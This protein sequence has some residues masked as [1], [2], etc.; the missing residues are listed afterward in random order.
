VAPKTRNKENTIYPRNWRMKLRGS[1]F[2]ILFRVP[3]RARELWGGR[4]EVTLG[5][6]DTLPAAEKAAYQSWADK[7]AFSETP[8]TM[9]TAFD[10]YQ[11][12]VLPLKAPAT[13][14]SNK[15][16]LNRLRAVIPQEMPVTEFRTHH[17]YQY[18]DACAKKE[19]KK[20][21]NL[22]LEVL[23]HVFTKCFEWGT[24]G[25]IEHPIVGKMSKISLPPRTRYPEDW[26]ITEFLKVANK[27]HRVY[28]PLKY[29]LGIDKSLM[30]RIQ[31]SSIKPD[32]LEIE[33][34]IKIKN[35]VK[36]K[37][38]SYMFQDADGND[39]GLKLIIDDVL[40][41][42][43]EILKERISPWLFCG[44][45]GQPLI[46][47]DGIA[48]TFDSNW[49]RAMKRALERTELVE[50]FTEHDIC[51]KTAS[52]A[53]TVEIAAKMRGHLNT[54]TTDKVYR[55]LPQKVMPLKKNQK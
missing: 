48:S 11:A 5:I 8:H 27:M 35:N 38:K 17:A 9:G 22:D 3:I 7:I 19:S 10:R 40:A 1:K 32:R 23:S 31:L 43:K 21:A 51:A 33:K 4:S 14:R 44:S 16:S 28:V 41:W 12:E 39:T 53:E 20:K 15:L 45:K 47:E 46:N 18:R 6:G 52:D 26:E 50:K 25:L 2:Y 55:R 42:R 49:Q 54:S 30:L 24:P 36:A 29:V 13:Q 37:K 34:R